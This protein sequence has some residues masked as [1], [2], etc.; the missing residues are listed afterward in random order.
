MKRQYLHF[1]LY[2]LLGLFLLEGCKNTDKGTSNK[3]ANSTQQEN[4]DYSPKY[5]KN[6]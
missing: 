3:K 5:N 4:I 6:N 2:L 1:V